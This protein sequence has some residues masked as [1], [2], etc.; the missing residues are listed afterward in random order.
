MN[1]YQAEIN[2]QRIWADNLYQSSRRELK[3]RKIMRRNAAKRAIMR[4][5]FFGRIVECPNTSTL[6][7]MR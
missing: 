5:P 6:I 2:L 4:Q 3:I 1:F 7:L